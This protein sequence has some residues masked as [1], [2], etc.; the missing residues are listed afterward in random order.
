[1]SMET[2]KRYETPSAGVCLLKI[3]QCILS[4]EGEAN[5]D[6]IGSEFMYDDLFGIF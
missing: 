5:I 2:K 6:T 4:G 1:M 3:E